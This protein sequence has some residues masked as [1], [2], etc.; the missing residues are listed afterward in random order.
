MNYLAT[1][2]SPL[3]KNGHPSSHLRKNTHPRKPWVAVHPKV[4]CYHSS[5]LYL[6]RFIS[7]QTCLFKTEYS[8]HL[9]GL[10][11]INYL[12][13]FLNYNKVI[14]RIYC[15][16]HSLDSLFKCQFLQNSLFK[17]N[18]SVLLQ[19]TLVLKEHKRLS[20]NTIIYSWTSIIRKVICQDFIILGISMEPQEKSW[21]TSK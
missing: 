1:I 4:Q 20:W 3:R 19:S 13:R 8:L 12:S 2:G 14:F 11:F 18:I 21:A 7:M 16:S 6:L 5:H 10:S 9:I 17:Q 15:Y